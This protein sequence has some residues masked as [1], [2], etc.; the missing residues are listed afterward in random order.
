MNLDHSARC[1]FF[2]GVRIGLVEL[3][4]ALQKR[5]ALILATACAALLFVGFL[6]GNAGGADLDAARAAGTKAG[7]VVG[8]KQG[9]EQGYDAGYKKGYRTSYKAAYE[10]AKRGDAD[11]ADAD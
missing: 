1:E 5:Y 8:K 11:A 3:S 10:R 4:T 9:K 6:I 7:E 2:V